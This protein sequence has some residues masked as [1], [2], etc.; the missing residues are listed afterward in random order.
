[1]CRITELCCFRCLMW[2][3]KENAK[4]CAVCGDWKCVSCGSCL[5]SLSPGEKKVAVAYMLGYEK[6]LAKITGVNYDMGRHAKIL[7]DVGM[8]N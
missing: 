8:T 6:A 5:C 1:M 2:F 7:N 3:A 4:E